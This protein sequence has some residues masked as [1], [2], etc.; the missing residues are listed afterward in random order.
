MKE[1]EAQKGIFVLVTQC[2]AQGGDGGN[3]SCLLGLPLH[4][5]GAEVGVEARV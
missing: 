3:G 5:P 4:I 2:S 1:V